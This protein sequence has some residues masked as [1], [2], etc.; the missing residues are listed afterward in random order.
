MLKWEWEPRSEED[1]QTPQISSIYDGWTQWPGDLKDK[2]INVQSEIFVRELTQNF[3]DA[4]RERLRAGS[5]I[6]PRLTFRFVTLKKEAAQA[7]AEK[8]D[9]NTIVA[10][11]ASFSPSDL[12]MMKL[13]DSQLYSSS[14]QEIRL[15]VV[16]ELGTT[17]M[18][19][20]WRRTDRNIDEDGNRIVRKMRDALLSTVGSKSDQGLGSYGEGKRAII[21]SSNIRALLTYTAFDASTSDDNVGRRFLGSLYW[22]AHQENNREFSGLALLGADP[23]SGKRRDPFA[24][25]E[26]DQILDELSIPGFV[27]RN[28]DDPADWGTSQVFIDPGVKPEEVLSGLARNWWPL[29]T[30][31]FSDFEVIDENGVSH[32][33]DLEDSKFQS[34]APFVLAYKG[35]IKSAE[36]SLP[37]SEFSNLVVDGNLPAGKLALLADVSDGG[38]SY[39]EPESNRSVVALVR[40][41]MLIQYRPVP[42][43]NLPAP[44]IRGVL[45]IKQS[46]AQAVEEHLRGVEP[47]LHNKWDTSNSAMQRQGVSIAKQV[48]KQL[49]DKLVQFRAQFLDES[50][51]RTTDLTLFDEMMSIAGENRVSRSKR[52]DESGPIIVV[53]TDDWSILAV[54]ATLIESDDHRQAQ[55]VRQI[56]L[57]PNKPSQTV[58]VEAGWE[59]RGD[60]KW[61]SEPRLSDGKAQ[62][63]VKNAA[64]IEVIDSD[65]AGQKILLEEDSTVVVTWVSK[66]YSD[67]WTVRPFVKVSGESSVSSAEKGKSDD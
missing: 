64:G 35:I 52:D 40:E 54:S 30:E 16:T 9:L 19:G 10:R 28:Q 43:G 44:F 12:R 48:H 8:I 59:V 41:G 42:D 47:P 11:Y 53:Q 37:T 65:L 61:E 26:A 22:R 63:K 67:L 46:E 17:G 60:S 5:E 49:R 6:R 25:D 33:V 39:K 7:F 31:S 14:N 3:V 32:V 57:R 21:G 38:W 58:F 62:F 27:K 23:V 4:A 51:R 55:A 18:S 15:L 29:L 56:K 36:Q 13:P 66:P 24:G 2:D 20:H 34:L 45:S 50:E 1:F